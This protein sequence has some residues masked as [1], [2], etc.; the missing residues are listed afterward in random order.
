MP[1]RKSVVS[2]ALLITYPTPRPRNCHRADDFE[3]SSS[4]SRLLKSGSWRCH[5]GAQVDASPRDVPPSPAPKRF[6][7]RPEGAP[8]ASNAISHAK[9]GRR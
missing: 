9:A 6:E 1:V 8:V 3:V 4:L 5:D 7:N 2:V